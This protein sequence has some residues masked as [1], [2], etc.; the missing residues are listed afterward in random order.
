MFEFIKT[1]GRIKI[2]LQATTV[3]WTRSEYSVVRIMC[4]VGWI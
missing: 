4:N 2:G 1:L 3:V